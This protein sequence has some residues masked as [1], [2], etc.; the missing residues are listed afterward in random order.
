MKDYIRKRA[1]EAGFDAVGVTS[2]D[3]VD[4]ECQLRDAVDAGRMAD[5][6]WLARDPSARCDPRSLLPGAKSVICCALAYGHGGIPG[7]TQR[8]QGFGVA[9]FARGADYHDVVRGKLGR[10]WDE[11]RKERPNAKAKLCADTSPILEKALAE[12]AGIG[13]IGKHTIL[14]NEVMGSWFMLGEIVTDL[15][16]EPDSPA[17]SMCGEC[18]KCIDRCPTGALTAPNVLDARRCISYLT[19]EAPRVSR[20]THDSPLTTHCFSYGC[21]ICQEACPYNN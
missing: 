12:R 18:R 7:R 13:W 2:A 20:S 19:I 6:G 1:R 17:E 5:M 21:D 11:I 10:L 9:R 15:E 14:V 8:K 16:I 4:I 3:P